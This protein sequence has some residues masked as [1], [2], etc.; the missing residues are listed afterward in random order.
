VCRR[1]A[2]ILGGT[3]AGLPE[4]RPGFIVITLLALAGA[5]ALWSSQAMSQASEYP[6]PAA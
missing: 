2:V 6:W 5:A 1:D 3:M 4:H